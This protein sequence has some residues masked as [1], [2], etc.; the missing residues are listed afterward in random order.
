MLYEAIWMGHFEIARELLDRVG[1]G[2]EGGLRHVIVKLLV[3]RDLDACMVVFCV[4]A[5]RNAT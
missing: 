1:R 4:C 3:Q 2:R 5:H